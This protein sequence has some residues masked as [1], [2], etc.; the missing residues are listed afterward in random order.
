M[1]VC[2]GRQVYV[3]VPL[4]GWE[5]SMLQVQTWQA[6]LQDQKGQDKMKGGSQ[7]QLTILET[8]SWLPNGYARQAQHTDLKVHRNVF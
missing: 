1:Y 5:F 3:C 7:D 6:W 2:E 4:W 8:M